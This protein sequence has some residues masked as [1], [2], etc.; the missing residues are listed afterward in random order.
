MMKEMGAGARYFEQFSLNLVFGNRYT[1]GGN[2]DVMMFPDAFLGSDG[3]GI[4][5]TESRDSLQRLE[6]LLQRS[7]EIPSR[8]MSAGRKWW[9]GDS[10]LFAFGLAAYILGPH[11]V[12]QERSWMVCISMRSHMEP[13]LVP[14]ATLMLPWLTA[15][16]STRSIVSSDLSTNKRPYH[17]CHSFQWY[18]VVSGCSSSWNWCSNLW[19]HNGNNGCDAKKKWDDLLQNE[20]QVHD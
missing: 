4:R 7:N 10:S 11:E 14:L 20:K 5:Q 2:R 12:D 8:I 6:S 19:H 1:F 18:S 17:D 16:T 9:A 13:W 3:R 15:S